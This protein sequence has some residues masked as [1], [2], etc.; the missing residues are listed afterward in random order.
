MFNLKII[1][2]LNAVEINILYYKIKFNPY[3]NK[4]ADFF[5]YPVIYNYYYRETPDDEGLRLVRGIRRAPWQTEA[6]P[7]SGIFHLRACFY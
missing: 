2:L 4:S 3:I 6:G 1:L 7:S 5:F